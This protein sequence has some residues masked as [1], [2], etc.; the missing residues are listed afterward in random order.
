M[1]DTTGKTIEEVVEEMFALLVKQGG[2]C[3]DE[4]GNC[5]YGD[6]LGNHCAI[7]FLI[8]EQMMDCSDGVD[9][10]VRN[11]NISIGANAGFIAM[12]LNV[13]SLCQK[14]HDTNNNSRTGRSL[15]S[16]YQIICDSLK[17][18]PPSL[19]DWKGLR[20]EQIRMGT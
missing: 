12:N 14:L 4:D 5:S 8:E 19:T 10:M 13:L 2:R 15:S 11:F 1:I 20:D 17:A 18:V 6:R 9:A 16:I 7:G 3:V